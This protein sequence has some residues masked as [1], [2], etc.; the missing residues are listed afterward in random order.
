MY[1]VIS[2]VIPH[3]C[4]RCGD[5]LSSGQLTIQWGFLIPYDCLRYTSRRFIIFITYC[6][7]VTI[8]RH[9]SMYWCLIVHFVRYT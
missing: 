2:F 1:M 9:Q 8:K 5:F 6:T 3:K 7:I 4:L